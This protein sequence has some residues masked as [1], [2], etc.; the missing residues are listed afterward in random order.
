MPTPRV[1]VRSSLLQW[2]CERAGYTEATFA[3]RYPSSRI[4]DWIS[5]ERHPTLR[6]LEDFASKTRT[7]VGYLFLP[8]P[9]EEE[10]PIPDFRTLRDE[11]VCRPSPDLLDTIYLCQQRQAWYREHQTAAHEPEL[12]FVSSATTRS[13]PELVAIK[14]RDTLGFS[15]ASRARVGTWEDALREFVLQ[16]EDAGVLVMISGIVGSN[17]SRALDPDEFR[18]FALSDPIAPVV[19]M[20]GADTKSAQMFTLAHE[21]AHLWLGQ[22]GVSDVSPDHDTDHD[23]ERWC[24]RVAAELLVPVGTLK[25]QLRDLDDPEKDL[26]RLVRYFKVSSLVVLRRMFDIGVLPRERFWA[27]YEKELRRLIEIA[28]RRKRGGDFYKTTPLRVSRRFA[29]A[30]I[31][32]TLEGRASYSDTLR[33]LGFRRMRT[34]RDLGHAVGIDV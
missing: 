26:K 6:Q 2:A 1:P 17:T 4:H 14:I 20:N 22:S 12:Q 24:N 19:F 15:V 11:S 5:G 3:E 16:A 32:A 29:R 9:P 25:K 30:I 23:V 7:P 8:E 10:I 33:L 18:G 13:E 31:S 21:L 28:S 34:F 27:A